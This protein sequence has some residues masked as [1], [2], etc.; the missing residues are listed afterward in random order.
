MV[1]LV[2]LEKDE[3]SQSRSG[4]RGINLSGVRFSLLRVKRRL[5]ALGVAPSTLRRFLGFVH[6][7]LEV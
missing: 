5:P 6:L 1:E 7:F 3:I 4:E 2:L